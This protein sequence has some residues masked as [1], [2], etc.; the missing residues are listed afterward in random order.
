MLQN[1]TPTNKDLKYVVNTACIILILLA[2]VIFF[3]K[4]PDAKVAT[5]VFNFELEPGKNGVIQFYTENDS[6]ATVTYVFHGD[7]IKA[8]NLYR[9]EFEEL[10]QRLYPD[11]VYQEVK[12]N[13]KL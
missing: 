3:S 7:T 11:T 2:V 1:R 12:T 9:E 5:S 6:L 4:A 13:L 8:K 10:V